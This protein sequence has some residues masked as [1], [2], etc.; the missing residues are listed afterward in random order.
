[1]YG[2]RARIG[3]LAPSSSIVAENEW[4]KMSP[5]G[6]V[7]VCSRYFIESPSAENVERMMEQMD[8]AAKEVASARVNVIAQCGAP[9]IYVKGFGYDK[10]VIDRIERVTGIQATTM[11]TATIAS[12]ERLG[13]RRIAIA[14]SYKPEMVEH[15]RRYF[16][17]AGFEVVGVKTLGIALNSEVGEKP[18]TVAYQLGRQAFNESPGAEALVLAAASLRTIEVVQA[19]E[20]DLGVP[21]TGNSLATF[22]HSLRLCGINEK[23]DGYGTL[24]KL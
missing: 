10:E 22:W 24:L 6:V 12:L 14:A 8:R 18:P 4:A 13:V 7:T 23:I 16:T 2:W 3:R 15:L 1:M 9:G 21:V 11:A 19:L 5:D 20:E 17:D